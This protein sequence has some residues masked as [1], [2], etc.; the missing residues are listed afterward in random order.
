VVPNGYG[1]PTLRTLQMTGDRRRQGQ[2][3]AVPS[4]SGIRKISYDYNLPITMK[5]NRAGPDGRLPGAAGPLRPPSG[6]QAGH[7]LRH[8][9]VHAVRVNSAA[10]TTDL[11]LNKTA[12]S[13]TVDDPSRQPGLAVDGDPNT[14]WASAWETSS[15]I[16]V[17]LGSTQTFDRVQLTW[18]YAY[19]ATFHHPGVGR[20]QHLGRREGGGQLRGADDDFVNGVKVF[21]RGGAWGW[22]ELLRRMPPDRVD[23]VV[24]MHRT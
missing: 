19:A 12:T 10:P 8:L 15:N 4:S 11:A 17:D 16:Q 13:S 7:Q 6:A 24:A 22:D 23:N 3:Q 21:I 9:A 14:R 2:R 1:D 18:E 5:D 20:R